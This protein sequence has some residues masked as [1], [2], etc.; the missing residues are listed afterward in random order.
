MNSK[1]I[2]F[3]TVDV[4]VSVAELEYEYLKFV[5]GE[6]LRTSDDV[7]RAQ[8]RSLQVPGV[9]EFEQW[10]QEYVAAIAQSPAPDVVQNGAGKAATNG[11]ASAVEPSLEPAPARKRRGGRKAAQPPAPAP[12][13]SEPRR[14]KRG[15]QAKPDA[16]IAEPDR[17]LAKVETNGTAPVADI[18]PEP[19]LQRQGRKPA[20]VTEI[21]QPDTPSPRRGRGRKAVSAE[22]AASPEIT[23]SPELEVA[24]AEVTPAAEKLAPPA[25]ETPIEELPSTLTATETPVDV[26]ASTAS[27][28]ADEEQADEESVGTIAAEPMRRR[29]GTG[30]GSTT[31]STT[32]RA[33][34]RRSPRATTAATRKPRTKRTAES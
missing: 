23:E 32:G 11:A 16:V 20:V 27:E 14:G 2:S 28:Q 24:A 19:T 12:T 22:N 25:A 31:G 21:I 15:R 7:F 17:S 6:T 5:C 33:A 34:A 13:A 30:K 29:R 18:P 10:R 9:P 3:Q 26:S 1:K 8:I 4:E